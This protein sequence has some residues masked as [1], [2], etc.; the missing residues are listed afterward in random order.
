MQYYYNYIIST[1]WL[2]YLKNKFISTYNI[3]SFKAKII[4]LKIEKF[5]KFILNFGFKNLQFK[6]LV[7]Y[8]LL[9]NENVKHNLFIFL[10]K[11]QLKSFDNLIFNK[12]VKDTYEF[13]I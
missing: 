12:A 9:G 5:K 8:R 13:F 10:I 1:G 11:F 7:N 2:K 3:N 4:K 6:D